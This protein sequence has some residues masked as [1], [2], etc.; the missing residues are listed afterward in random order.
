M[1]FKKDIDNF[2]SNTTA[3]M[4]IFKFN[5][6]TNT[7]KLF[8]IA[9]TNK[10]FSCTEKGSNYPVQ[11]IKLT[12]TDINAI[13]QHCKALTNENYYANC[14]KY[15]EDPNFNMAILKNDNHIKVIYLSDFEDFFSVDN[16]YNSNFKHVIETLEIAQKYLYR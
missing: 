11:E 4:L 15:S 7:G 9:K 13:E 12:T 6:Q 1:T 3:G 16:N 5:P 10:G 14:S 2:K 8:I